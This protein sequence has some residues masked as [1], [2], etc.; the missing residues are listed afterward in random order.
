MKTKTL[1]ALLLLPVLGIG[2]ELKTQD[3]LYVGD[4]SKYPA[5]QIKKL[6]QSAGD[7]IYEI[8]TYAC[9]IS[10]DRVYKNEKERQ[11]IDKMKRDVKKAYPYA[12]LAKAKLSE[13]ETRLAALKTESEK[14]KYAEKAEKEIVDQF[15]AD[16]RNMTLSQGKILMKLIDRETG[17]DSYELI[18]KYRGGFSALMWQGVAR[19][20]GAN[21]KTD[22]DEAGDDKEIEHIVDLID[23]GMI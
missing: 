2:Q 20:F 18:K 1:F 9:V 4:V 12:I 10:A 17:S 14:K 6:P 16:I 7:T 13:Y 15:E 22:Y 19:I 23:L 3:E 21:L 11:K 8:T 5:S